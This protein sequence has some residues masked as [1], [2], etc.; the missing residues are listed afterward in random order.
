L[1]FIKSNVKNSVA[2]RHIIFFQAFT[3]IAVFNSMRM[4]I[5]FLPQTVK[6][7]AEVGVLAKY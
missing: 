2:K 1:G 3:I 6:A 7:A 4:V 5:S